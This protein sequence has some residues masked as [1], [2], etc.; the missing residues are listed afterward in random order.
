MINPAS[1]GL[2]S[3]AGMR[4]PNVIASY[5]EIERMNMAYNPEMSDIL[6]RIVLGVEPEEVLIQRFVDLPYNF[7]FTFS[8]R[9][10]EHSVLVKNAQDLDEALNNIIKPMVAPGA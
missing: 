8:Y 7:A 10:I 2:F 4:V 6:S 5:P 3:G 1:F 9:G